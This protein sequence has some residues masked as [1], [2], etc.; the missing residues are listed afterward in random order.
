M[1]PSDGIGIAEVIPDPPLVAQM[2]EG[3]I[4]VDQRATSGSK[5]PRRNFGTVGASE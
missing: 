5:R 4:R 1:S 2:N 3:S